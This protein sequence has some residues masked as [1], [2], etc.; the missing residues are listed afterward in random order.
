MRRTNYW[1]LSVSV[2]L[3]L[4]IYLGLVAVLVRLESDELRTTIHN[5]S[6]GVWFLIA[7]LTTVGYGDA[8]PASLAGRCIGVF[9]LLTS[10]EFY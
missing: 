4:I 5:F 9:F 6:D 1:K 10:L 3:V 2:V 8:T 7:T